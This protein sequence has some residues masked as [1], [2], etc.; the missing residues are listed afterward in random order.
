MLHNWVTIG[1]S[2]WLTHSL[3]PNIASASSLEAAVLLRAPLEATYIR[4][5]RHSPAKDFHPLQL[6]S[7]N[8]VEAMTTMLTSLG[9]PMTFHKPVDTHGQTFT[10]ELI[11]ICSWMGASP[12]HVAK[13]VTGHQQRF[14]KAAVLVIESS[15]AD[16]VWHSNAVQ[17]QRLAPAVSLIQSTC[18]PS[19]TSKII[20]HIF[21]NGGAQSFCQLA[22]AYR[23]A[24]G[25][26]LP[27]RTVVCDSVPGR[28]T[29]RR[30][31]TAMTLSLPKNPFLRPIGSGIVCIFV[32]C[33]FVCDEAFGLENVV[34][35]ARRQLLNQHFLDSH[36]PRL[37]LYSKADEL[38]GWQDVADHAE[39][40]RKSG[41]KDVHEVVF[42]KSSH[43]NHVKE[44]EERYWKGVVDS[45]K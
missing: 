10:D 1:Y 29:W 5:H 9:Y 11:I 17:Q 3:I 45:A 30:S 19:T 44:D 42:E 25:G 38:V 15:L 16:V 34:D 23:A 26:A 33:A 20:L 40:A 41:V 24:T 37:Y 28:A 4:P 22:A 39:A 8:G 2:A 12:R 21:S 43:V 18:A 32:A 27:V 35:K 36:V 7:P 14:P 31:F 13:Y 6:Q